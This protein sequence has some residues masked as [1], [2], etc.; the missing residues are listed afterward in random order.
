MS[1][2]RTTAWF[3]I[4]FAPFSAFAIDI[5][6][7]TPEANDRFDPA[8]FPTTV[9]PNPNSQ[10]VA[11]GYDLSSLSF[12]PTPFSGVIYHPGYALIT[13]KHVVTATHAGV[14]GPVTFLGEQGQATSV[15]FSGGAGT[16]TGYPFTPRDLSIG[17]LATKVNKSVGVQWAPVL[18]LAVKVSGNTSYS[19]W[20]NQTVF[21][22]GRNQVDGKSPR[23]A[24]SYISSVTVIPASLSSYYVIPGTSRG[25]TITY[26]GGDSGGATY[27][28][29]T[30]PTG[31]KILTVL[32]THSAVAGTFSNLD[33]F[34]SSDHALA[35]INSLI[36]A[37]GYAVQMVGN[38]SRYWIGGPG[39]DFTQGSAW[40]GGLVPDDYSYVGFDKSQATSQAVALAAGAQARG[41][42]FGPTSAGDVG[43]SLSGG[44]LTLGRGGMINYS[45]QTQ[46]IS[47]NVALADSQWWIARAGDLAISGN[48]NTNGGLMI[49]D[50]PKDTTLSGTISGVGGSLAK[51]GSG[52]LR[53]IGNG[54]SSYS[55][56]NTI[57]SGK[58][59]V[60][61]GMPLGSGQL[62]VESSG[63]LI[64]SAGTDIV[65]ELF[66]NA[67][68]TVGGTGRY[69][70]QFIIGN[71]V[72]IRPGDTDS[73]MGKLSGTG[74][75]LGERG[76]FDLQ[77]GRVNPGG[78]FVWDSLEAFYFNFN[79]TATAANP[80][81]IR[82]DS[83]GDF[84]LGLA[85]NESASWAIFTVGSSNQN[86]TIVG[87]SADKF[88]L[89]KTNFLPQGSLSL[90]HSG[91]SIMLN[92]TAVPEPSVA[93]MLIG[94]AVILLWRNRSRKS[95]RK[96]LRM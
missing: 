49:I 85:P 15:N 39:T 87:F 88:V 89:D 65:N 62:Y 51:E 44:N 9:L 16:G 72:T 19:G 60:S 47:S 23:I 34:V 40:T 52:T 55:G 66:L 61:G 68:S 81:T 17:T 64:I 54:S 36:K 50:G 86:P 10:F 57:H 92:Y 6:G 42:V 1:R 70:N 3:C 22:A 35:S 11:A 84:T 83:L 2:G 48:I 25:G 69:F 73:G 30:D 27:I 8:T 33:N 63:T 41:L 59:I 56:R 32:G 94:V 67:G 37:S 96:P 45:T 4:L 31:A 91:Q 5:V 29:W 14:G 76:I 28:P 82:L 20:D 90:T 46:T 53:V 13:P 26:I 12:N 58:V 80:F 43:F 71:D 24:Q 75:F 79:V 74:M 78:P 18:D 21:I 38:A 93:A 7:Y 95:L 77:I